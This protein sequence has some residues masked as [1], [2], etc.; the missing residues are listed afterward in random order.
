MNASI[1]QLHRWVSVVFTL[2]VVAVSI[3]GAALEEPAEW[4]FLLPLAPL[5]ALFFTGVYLFVLPYR[6]R[7][8]RAGTA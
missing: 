8:S 1:R 7:R 3:L 6:R 2:A 5:A 4:V